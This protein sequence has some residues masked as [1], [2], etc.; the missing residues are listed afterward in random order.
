MTR[1]TDPDPD[2]AVRYFRYRLGADD[3][4][5]FRYRR[6]ADDASVPSSVPPEAAECRDDLSGGSPPSISPTDRAAYLEAAVRAL[7]GAM[8]DADPPVERTHDGRS[9]I[10]FVEEEAVVVVVEGFGEL[11]DIDPGIAALIAF[12]YSLDPEEAL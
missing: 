7:V 2:L 1:N 11:I 4:W 9:V 6:R 5:Y 3:A 10:A 12:V 8:T